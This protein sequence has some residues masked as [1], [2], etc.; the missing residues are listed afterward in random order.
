YGDNNDQIN[1]YVLLNHTG[2]Q[3]YFRNSANLNVRFHQDLKSVTEGL[4]FNALFNMNA[5][6]EITSMRFK[7]PALYYARTRKRNGELNLE[8]IRAA[9]HPPFS[10]GNAVNRKFY[11]ETRANYDRSFGEHYVTGLAHFYIEDF[12]DSK[13]VS[14]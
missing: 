8:K 2:F 6:S 7:S 10:V 13:N 9:S 11:M 4:S 12:I 14:D 5:N 3:K 1:P